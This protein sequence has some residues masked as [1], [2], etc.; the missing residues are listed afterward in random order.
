MRRFYSL[1]VGVFRQLD[2]PQLHLVFKEHPSSP[3]CY[4]DLHRKAGG[5]ARVHFVNNQ[6]TQDA[7]RDMPKSIV[8]I[9]SSVGIESLL[10]DKPVIVLG[11]CLLQHPRAGP[12]R[13]GHATELLHAP[14]A[15]ARNFTHRPAAAPQLSFTT[16]ETTTWCRARNS[17]RT[18]GNCRP[19]RNR[20][21]AVA[22]P[23]ATA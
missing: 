16:C 8:T 4:P 2:D 5:E 21:R 7:H 19:W 1:L 22:D 23:R 11:L 12:D 3:A 17:A 18:K 15:S 6:S 13:P 9:N 20:I 14:C 10:F